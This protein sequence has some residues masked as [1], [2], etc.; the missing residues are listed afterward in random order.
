MTIEDR[1]QLP[2]TA[3]KKL[4]LGAGVV[5]FAAQ[6]IAAVV[7][8]PRITGPGDANGGL[9]VSLWGVTVLWSVAVTLLIVRQADLPDIATAAM[10]VTIA[11]FAAFTLSAAYDVRGGDDE[12]NMVDALFLGVTSGALSA[13]VVWGIAMFVAR[14]LKLPTSPERE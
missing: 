2:L 14:V 8:A 5:M 3:L 6:V 11:T 4:M 9:L 10:L 12:V 13:M 1:P 7:V